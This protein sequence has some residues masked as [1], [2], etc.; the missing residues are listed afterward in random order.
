MKK[1]TFISFCML[2]LIV[3]SCKKTS[4]EVTNLNQPSTDV[5]NSEAG[6]ISYAKG[7]YKIGFG[8]QA[9]GSLDDGLGYGMQ[10]IVQAFH[11]SMGDNIFVPWGNNSY[12]FADNPQW[13]KLDNGTTVNNPI[14]QGQRFEL[15]LRND[16]AYGASNSFLPEWT[17]MYFLNNSANVLL[18]KV[19]GTAFSGD[20]AAKK[21]ILKAWA[22]WWK[23]YAYCR[24]GSMYIAGIIAET[25]NSTN[26]NFVTN[27][28]MVAEGIKNLD[29]ASALLTPIAAAGAYNDLMT[30]V[31]PAFMQNGSPLTPAEWIR[32]I[33]T[34]KAR[35]ILVNK[36]VATMTAADWTT[37]KGLVDNG[38]KSSD[39][40]FNIRT[41]SDNSKSVIDKDF[42]SIGSYAATDDPTFWPSERLI[43]DFK[44]GDK[45][46][47]NNFNLLGSAVIN[48]RG[49]S[50][51]FGTRYYLKDGGNGNGAITY[52]TFDYGVDNLNLAGTYEENELMKA[53]CLIQ[54]SQIDAGVT[55][56]NTI[57]TYQGAGV[58]SPM[59][60]TK[61]LA[62]EELRKERRCA[63][64]L[65]GVA[66]YDARRNG[67]TEDVA[68][69]G[70]RTGCV[71]LDGNGV[72][73][74]NCQIN[75]K[76]LPYWDVP[77]N[78]L[79]FNAPATGSAPVK[80]Q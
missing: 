24:I 17:Y 19:D 70:G 28:A 62:L 7:F 13:V 4:L 33:N 12:K 78:E 15:K 11:E 51:T 18:S 77:Q 31:I 74:T 76:Y 55:I 34:F 26:G 6:V 58:S 67:I 49:R 54:T 68:N 41:F 75:Y 66:F 43:Q 40:A 10:L 35:S 5:L 36:T 69:G 73:N 53:E 1:I 60:L 20:A 65:R 2:L 3:Q 72:V 61:A 22:Y 45:R 25:P 8:D 21:N 80:V 29:K 71:V 63:L 42:G 27:A 57:R 46:K 37:V 50:I 14:G 44:A 39:Y 38:I 79:D 32:N 16:R 30:T 47:T 64:F 52:F 9:V 48:K 23:G 56:I 59:G